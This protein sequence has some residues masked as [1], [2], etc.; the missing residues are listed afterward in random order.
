MLNKRLTP[1]EAAALI[2][3]EAVV[4]VSSSSGRILGWK[5]RVTSEQ[6]ARDDSVSA[7]STAT[8]NEWGPR[9]TAVYGSIRGG[10]GVT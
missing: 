5:S 6:P 2:P 4:T 7:R 8:V 3:D 10:A 1:A 9:M